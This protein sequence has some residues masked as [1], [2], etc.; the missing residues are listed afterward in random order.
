M[1]TPL[2]TLS[3]PV[4][5]AS[6]QQGRY[7]WKS[8]ISTDDIDSLGERLDISIYDEL[9]QNFD[10]WKRQNTAVP[11]VAYLKSKGW[12][13]PILDPAHFSLQVEPKD[14]DSV[15]IG[16]VEQLWRDGKT[17]KAW[18]W[19]DDT[20]VGLRAFDRVRK[21]DEEISTSVC[22]VP[23][24]TRIEYEGATRV[25]KG[26]S[27]LAYMDHVGLTTIPVNKFTDFE[28]ITKSTAV[29]SVEED[30]LAVL[31]DE[32]GRKII[33][34]SRYR[35]GTLKSGAVPAVAKSNSGE[36]SMDTTNQATPQTPVASA[37]APA[38]QVTAP[39]PTDPN[40]QTAVSAVVTSQEVAASQS[41]VQPAQVGQIVPALASVPT[42]APA[43]S[44]T[45]VLAALDAINAQSNPFVGQNAMP[46]A[47][48]PLQ[49]TSAQT[50]LVPQ[51]AQGQQTGFAPYNYYQPQMPAMQPVPLSQ[52]AQVAPQQV[53]QSVPAQT[54]PTLTLSL[55]DLI[56]LT[57]FV[58]RSVLAQFSSQLPQ[59]GYVRRSVP[60][61]MMPVSA[62]I[63]QQAAQQ[64]VV[65]SEPSTADVI[66][67]LDQQRALAQGVMYPNT[68]WLG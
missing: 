46:P 14:R 9:I 43:A 27:G 29:Q 57:G 38:V 62:M 23:D 55:S 68:P 39:Q 54:S 60:P 7:R 19:F 25:Y 40:V 22:F 32:V 13:G 41:P 17:L 16:S 5:R 34:L 10:A 35:R 15:R 56:A 21:G 4:V 52:P 20:E 49:A 30:V 51:F 61:G 44:L 6:I 66:N 11:V 45:D 58:A 18:G 28:A 24:A 64:P 31:G 1:T 33:S 59:Q 12:T 8:S 53:S 65:K 47:V 50:Q 2:V 36:S 48:N 3:M 42:P 37:P 26:G 63:Q 67:Q